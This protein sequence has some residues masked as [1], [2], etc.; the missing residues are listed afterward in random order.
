MKK[1]KRKE[2]KT[3]KALTPKQSKLIQ[4]ISNKEM[5]VVEGPAGTGK[6]FVVA[7]LAAQALKSGLVDKIVFS[8]P[9][10]PCGKSI[11]FL[12]GTL[13]EKLAPWIMPFMM[14]ISQ[15]FSQSE[16]EMFVKN[17]KITTMPFETMRGMSFDNSFIILDEAQNSTPKEMR[18]FLTRTGM[19]SKTVI[20]GD[21]TQSD[22]RQDESGLEMAQRII[23]R[24]NIDIAIIRFDSEDVVRSGLCKVWVKAFEYKEP[25]WGNVLNE[26][27]AFITK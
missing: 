13:E 12:P 19:H 10:V 8:R 23:R 2:T 24:D 22:V 16:I 11:G 18:M 4:A 21:S 15:Y 1:D 7:S 3:L 25:T 26:L 14:V 5:V 27:P 6:T 20:L 9:V 17:G